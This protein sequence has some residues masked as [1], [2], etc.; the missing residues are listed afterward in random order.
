[1]FVIV[2]A[3]SLHEVLVIVFTHS[4]S[5]FFFCSLTGPGPGKLL[6]VQLVEGGNLFWLS[7]HTHRVHLDSH[8]PAKR[9]CKQSWLSC[10]FANPASR[11]PN[12]I[13]RLDEFISGLC[14]GRPLFVGF[15]LVR[16]HCI[17]ID[18]LNVCLK[19]LIGFCICVW[20]WNEFLCGFFDCCLNGN[21]RW[22]TRASTIGSQLKLCH[23]VVWPNGVRR[24]LNE[25]LSS[26]S[27]RDYRRW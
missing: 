2:F 9:K 19:S 24:P 21:I 22:Q 1:M 5:I 12:R 26:L 3:V 7:F 16:C 8:R 18:L 6:G 10:F 23:F 11:P 25:G 4:L 17:V 27:S 15:F 20:Q 13:S 14:F